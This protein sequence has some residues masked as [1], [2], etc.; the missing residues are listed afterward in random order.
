MIV[1]TG[2][3]DDSQK[4]DALGDTGIHVIHH[5]SLLFWRSQAVDSIAVGGIQLGI[6]DVW[7]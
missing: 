1:L 3:V 2:L 7:E 6:F 5:T 4:A